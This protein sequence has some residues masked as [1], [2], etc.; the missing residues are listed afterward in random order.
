MK[1]R[2]F[3]ADRDGVRLDIYLADQLEM[4]RSQIKNGITSGRILV[5]GKKVK[6]G[7]SLK[8]EDEIHFEEEEEYV[9][10][11]KDLG[12]N[13]LYEDDYIACVD[14][15]YGLVVHPGAGEEEETLVHHIL[16]R[17][18]KVSKGSDPLRP[19]I[20][21]RLDKDTSGVMV[22]AK[23]DEAYDGL[24]ECFKTRAVEKRYDAICHGVIREM[25][26]IDSPIG[27]DPRRRTQMAV[28]VHPSKPAH[29]IYEPVMG[30]RDST[31]LKVQILTGRTHQI[32]VHLQ[33]IHHPVVGDPIYGVK[34]ERNRKLLLHSASIKF[35]HPITDEIIYAEAPMPERLLSY[36]R[37]EEGD[38]CIKY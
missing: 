6:A 27:R 13:I 14:K 12:V 2:L 8:T 4:N 3:V 23:T 19:G 10:E 24:I 5:N 28:N 16:W 35:R 25:G 31:L 34:R 18:G 38:L 20:V 32:R 33:S 9:I 11:P 37:K 29:T 22:V 1:T 26:T 21:H 7:Y 17:F 30:F 36:I 15:P